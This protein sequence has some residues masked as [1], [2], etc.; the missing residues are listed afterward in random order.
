MSSGHGHLVKTHSEHKHHVLVSQPHP[1]TTELFDLFLGIKCG[2]LRDIHH[3]TPSGRVRRHT[4]SS[5]NTLVTCGLSTKLIRASAHRPPQT[6]QQDKVCHTHGHTPNCC[7]KGNLINSPRPVVH[8][9]ALTDQ[10][11]LYRT[12]TKY[13][14][15]AAHSAIQFKILQNH[16]PR[17]KA[18]HVNQRP[19]LFFRQRHHTHAGLPLCTRPLIVQRSPTL[20]SAPIRLCPPA[21]KT[22]TP[23]CS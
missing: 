9:A 16:P 15:Q 13:P 5:Q 14:S 2:R 22:G 1:D 21:W 23:H 6:N 4:P 17:E 20:D 10:K 18:R 7:C 3:L 8:R 12:L 19:N 11:P